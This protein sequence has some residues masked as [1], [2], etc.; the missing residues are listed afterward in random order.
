MITDIFKEFL[1][2]LVSILTGVIFLSI[3]F[4]KLLQ[5]NPDFI[6]WFDAFSRKLLDR[7]SDDSFYMWHPVFVV[8]NRSLCLFYEKMSE[9]ERFFAWF[10]YPEV[11][12]FFDSFIFE[13]SSIWEHLFSIRGIDNLF[14][15]E[16]TQYGV[17]SS[18]SDV[19]II[20]LSLVSFVLLF[21]LS[22]LEEDRQNTQFFFFFGLVFWSYFAFEGLEF[23]KAAV[24]VFL[25][26]L[27]GFSLKK[28]RK[29]IS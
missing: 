7:M 23:N 17:T 15:N 3:S 16:Y 18:L 1:V 10:I 24:L 14:E 2:I 6:P 27:T 20:Y 8:L 5:K 4:F 25:C 11:T 22:V 21:T 28:I 9:T 12:S 29:L 19:G 26:L 13:V